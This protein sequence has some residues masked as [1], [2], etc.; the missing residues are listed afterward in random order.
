[1]AV[2]ADAALR[3]PLTEVRDISYPIPIGPVQPRNVE[4]RE[5][6]VLVSDQVKRLCIQ[7]GWYAGRPWLAYTTN[8]CDYYYYYYYSAINKLVI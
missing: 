1:M 4:F 5:T 3:D 2:S 7:D 6:D 8:N